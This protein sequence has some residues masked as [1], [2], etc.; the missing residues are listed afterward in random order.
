MINKRTLSILVLSEDNGS[1]GLR[2]IQ[3]IL[4][5]TFYQLAGNGRVP[6]IH[7]PPVSQALNDVCKP[8]AWPDARRNRDVRA[9]R[10]T[11]GNHLRQKNGFCFFHVD[12]D[13]RWS[14]RTEST[15]LSAFDRHIAQPVCTWLR[16]NNT[17]DLNRT[18]SKLFLLMPHY[19]I[20]AWVYQNIERALEICH[21]RNFERDASRFRGWR[22]ARHAIDEVHQIKDNVSLAARFNADLSERFPVNNALAAHTSFEAAYCVIAHHRRFR[23]ALRASTRT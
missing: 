18:M 17:P 7:Y 9:L 5:R 15:H 21:Q 11:I 3:N 6:G 16:D 19:S 20:E 22:E 8:S 13:T 23:A 12:G 1:G 10:Q 14:E 4:T 2:T